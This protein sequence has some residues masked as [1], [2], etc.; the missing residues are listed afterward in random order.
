MLFLEGQP[1][2]V[3]ALAFA[4]DGEWLAIGTS[5]GAIRLWS[6]SGETE[7]AGHKSASQALAFSPDGRYLASGGT[8]KALHVWNVVDRTILVIHKDQAHGVTSATFVG[9]KTVL[10]GIGER[11]NP[12]ARPATLFLVDL[13]SGALRKF[14]FGVVNGIRA[15]AGQAEQRLSIWATDTKLLRVQDITRPAM[16]DVVLKN[17]CRALALS[18]DGRRLAVSSD[19]EVLLFEVDRWPRPAATLGRHQGVVSAL[20]FSPDGR[21]LLSGGWD[22]SVRSWDVDRGVERTNYA[23]PVGRVSALAIAADGLRAAVGGDSGTVA[24][25]DLE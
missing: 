7:L 23:W 14:P 6:S 22:Q 8:D 20:A 13:P 25:W 4:P 10:F 9:T 12:V 5:T 21:T 24:I 16:R 17:D 11:P 18:P 3:P 2:V 1:G 15:V 19:W